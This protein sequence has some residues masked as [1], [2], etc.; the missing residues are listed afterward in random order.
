AAIEAKMLQADID[1]NRQLLD[2]LL[3]SQKGVEVSEAGM[4]RNN[5]RIAEA[6]P[7]PRDPVAPKRMQNILLS[8]LLALIG[9][10]GLV[11]FLDYLH[12]KL[13]SVEY[14]D[15]YLRLPALGVIPALDQSGKARRLL[16]K[17]GGVQ[18]L[19]LNGETNGGS[20]GKQL[21][22]ATAGAGSVILTQIEANS[23][24]ADNYRALDTVLIVSYDR[25]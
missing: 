17:T 22:T 3:Q 14:I 11:L 10:I 6:S 1:S 12:N 5:I 21:A 19:I 2:S 15:R 23:S 8:A 13:E 24:N 18:S 7:L 20:A 9:G 16:A 25:S 4:L